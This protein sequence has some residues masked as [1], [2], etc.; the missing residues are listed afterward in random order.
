MRENEKEQEELK[1][2]CPKTLLIKKSVLVTLLIW[3]FYSQTSFTKYQKK[4]KQ[5][6]K[7]LQGTNWEETKKM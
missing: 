7:L 4:K 3:G 2:S 1:V 6:Q 5:K